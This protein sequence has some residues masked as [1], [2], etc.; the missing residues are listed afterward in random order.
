MMVMDSILNSNLE[1]LILEDG[2][3]TGLESTAHY[4]DNF[5][6]HLVANYYHVCV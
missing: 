6:R 2:I 5:V 1:A 3:I 4:G